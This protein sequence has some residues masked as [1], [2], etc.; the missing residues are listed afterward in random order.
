MNI[1]KRAPV[2]NAQRLGISISSQVLA[3]TLAP[4][5]AVFLVTLL[6]LWQYDPL[7]RPLYF[8]P[9]IFAYI[10][11]LVAQGFAPHKYAFNEQASLAF[12]LG[13]AAMRLGDLINLHH[14]LA[15]RALAMLVMASA[16]ALT[17]ITGI[18][19]TR[20]R[21][22]AFFSA[23]ILMGYEGYGTRAATI[24]EPKSL[25]LVFGLVTLYFLSKRKWGWA[26]ACAS[27]AG[28]AWQIGWG[29]LLVA[30]LLALI[31]GGP[32]WNARL[33]ACAFTLGAALVVF[34]VYALYFATQDALGDML[35]QTF[36][37]P[38]LMHNVAS[39]TV[40]E[41]LFKLA[42]RFYFGFGTHIVFGVLGGVGFLAWLAAHL[43]PWDSRAFLRRAFYFWFQNRRTAGTLLVIM[44]LAMYS[45]LDFENFP[46]WIPLLPFISLFAAWLVWTLGVRSLKKL[47]VSQTM[48]RVTFAALALVIFAFSTYHAFSHTGRD[49]PVRGQTWQAEQRVADELNQKLGGDAALWIAGKPE[50]LFFMQRQNINKYIYLIGEVD[51]AVDAFEPGGFRQMLAD[52]QKQKPVLFAL[53]RA[54]RRYFSSEANFQALHQLEKKFVRLNRCNA[55][56]G[57]RFFVR[58]DLADALFP[59]GGRGCLT[60]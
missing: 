24:L 35:Q 3:F 39:K 51:A 53:G 10:A 43:R 44:G 48:Q 8:D 9:G 7:H 38:I 25:M 12:L 59:P 54:D 6:V 18:V 1:A 27:A 22:I 4:P 42:E 21:V 2:A 47:Q 41:R 46:D 57:G 11:Q 37:A 26:G 40:S 28:L 23:L 52:A 29:Y 58:P 56:G 15:Y 17:Y 30:L 13:G 45:Y 19:F 20:S 55:L 60:R 32:T 16:V 5:L 31:Q 33:R 36:L 34:L 49:Q 14:L 50:L